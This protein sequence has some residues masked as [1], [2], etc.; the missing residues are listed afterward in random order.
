MAHYLAELIQTAETAEGAAKQEAEDRA[1]NL[2]IKL[3]A[4]RRALPLS[5]DP[6]SGY[7]DAIKV[8]AALLPSSDPWRRFRRTGTSDA[9]LHDMF[10]AMVQLVM[11]G[12]LLTR[13]V[14]MR[15]ILDAEWEALSDEEQLLVEVL[16]RW[17]QFFAKPAPPKIDLESFYAVFA[18]D[19]E[20]PVADGPAEEDQGAAGPV[21]ANRAEILSHVETFQGRLGELVAQWRQAIAQG[22]DTSEESTE[23][24]L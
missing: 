24:D 17:H 22:A 20:T 8:L 4:N 9:L 5:A 11:G 18:D 16:N 13:D 19:D 2:I 10:G 12:L 14:E 7:R 21:A 1:A 15:T 23:D 6:L 3:W